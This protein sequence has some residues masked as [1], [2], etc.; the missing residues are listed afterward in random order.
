MRKVCQASRMLSFCSDCLGGAEGCRCRFKNLLERCVD[1]VGSLSW[2]SSA[3]DKL[4]WVGVKVSV[5]VIHENHKTENTTVLLDRMW[6]SSRWE[7]PGDILSGHCTALKPCPAF[8]VLREWTLE[9][10][11]SFD[12]RM[13]ETWQN[14]AITIQRTCAAPY[15]V[16]DT[17]EEDAQKTEGNT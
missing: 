2:G 7:L 5:A 11:V 15:P 8:H 9:Q 12:M 1:R 16:A 10:S 14:E 6:E 17:R 4:S 13:A 3:R